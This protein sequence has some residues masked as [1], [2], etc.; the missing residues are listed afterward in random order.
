MRRALPVDAAN[1]LI[2]DSLDSVKLFKF[3]IEFVCLFQIDSRIRTNR[4]E[5]VNSQLTLNHLIRRFVFVSDLPNL[6]PASTHPE[7]DH[8]KVGR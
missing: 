7:T 1:R 8:A 6:S 4:S 2:A 3:E 5:L